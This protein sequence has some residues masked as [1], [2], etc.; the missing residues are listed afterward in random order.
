MVKYVVVILSTVLSVFFGLFVG[1]RYAAMH[2]SL[3]LD[4]LG[5]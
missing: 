1:Q 5:T 4:H 2:V 3:F